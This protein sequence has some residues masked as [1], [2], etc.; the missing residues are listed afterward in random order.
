MCWRRGKRR[1]LASELC[2]R[3][4]LLGSLSTHEPR[5][6]HSQA[7]LSPASLVSFSGQLFDR[8]AARGHYSERAASQLMR[9][10]VEVVAFCHKNNVIHRDLKPE[11]FLMADKREEAPVKVTDFGLSVFYKEGKWPSFQ[12]ASS[13]LP[14]LHPLSPSCLV[15][16]LFLPSCPVCTLSLPSC[17]DCNLFFSER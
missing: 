3:Y 6:A 2:L 17:P 12:P 13:I 9:T 11:N 14:G 8:I 1:C 5:L 7:C 10:I 15:C 16:T 4:A